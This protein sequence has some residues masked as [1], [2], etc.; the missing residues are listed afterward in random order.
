MKKLKREIFNFISIQG[1]IFNLHDLRSDCNK[2]DM[3]T[4][5]ARVTYRSNITFHIS[6]M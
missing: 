1:E 6:L 4:F 5:V 3:P 2:D